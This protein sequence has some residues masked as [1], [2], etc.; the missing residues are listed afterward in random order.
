DHSYDSQYYA[1]RAIEPFLADN[2]LL[3]VDDCSFPQVRAANT[4]FCRLDP[5]VR[6][7]FDIASDYNGEPK[8]WNGVQILS[9][10]RDRRAKHNFTLVFFKLAFEMERIN[11]EFLPYFREYRRHSI[12]LRSFPNVLRNT[13]VYALYCAVGKE[14]K[15]LKAKKRILKHWRYITGKAI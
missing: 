8:W 14:Q 12:L 13:I 1:I 6:L 5:N 3:I 11:F 2:A 10:R 15:A 9:Y 4:L 7:L